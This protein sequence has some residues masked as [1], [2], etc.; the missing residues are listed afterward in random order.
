MTEIVSNRLTVQEGT[1]PNP[2]DA[3]TLDYTYYRA[4]REIFRLRGR[5]L[6]RCAESPEVDRTPRNNRAA[7]V[8]APDC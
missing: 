8:A 2:Q 7:G 1:L 4:I 3:L 5:D 6:N